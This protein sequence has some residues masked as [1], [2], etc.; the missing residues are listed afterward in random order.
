MAEKQQ[1][2]REGLQKFEEELHELKSVR[3]K[4]ISQKIKVAREQ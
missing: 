3:R 1:L 2:S 4:E